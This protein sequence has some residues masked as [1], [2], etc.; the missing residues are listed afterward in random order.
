MPSPLKS[1]L[2]LGIET[3]CD[4]TAAAVLRGPRDVLS[5]IIASQVPIHRR[6]GGVVPE[7]A[8]R[9]HILA[10]DTVVTE[11]L[12]TAGV[13]LPELGG[14]AV[15]FGP[16][17]VGSLL[18][19]VSVAK[20]LAMVHELPLA[21]VNHHEG[22]IQS[23]FIE[24]ADIPLPMIMLMV[25]GGDTSLYLIPEPGA[26][27]P[28]AHTRDDAAGEAYDKVSK[29]LGLGYPGGPIIDR[30]AKL[31]DP[32]AV[33]FTRPR[34]SDGTLDFSFSGMKTAVL[35]YVQANDIRPISSDTNA[36]GHAAASKPRELHGH[37]TTDVFPASN[38]G[39]A[40]SPVRDVRDVQDVPARVLDLLASFQES[41]V[42]YLIDHTVKA[43][44]LHQARSIGLSG[45]VAC[46]SR[47]REAARQTGERLGIP[48]FFP[49]PMLTT[50]NGAMIASAGYHHLIQGR[51]AGY[52][53]NA[54]PGARL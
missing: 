51:R 2:I 33:A 16:G 41:L 18:I 35:R 4:E 17:L 48:V 42:Q 34:M 1:E 28:L 39:G 50:D 36:G 5:N 38:G 40:E 47:L 24:H 46:N 19:G 52:S 53:L 11:A 43:A 9:Q 15:T 14:I 29:L 49:S 31:G 12:C 6:F 21:A 3:S 25:S 13:T 44:R 8:S 37:A 32:K 54:D 20:S 7:L 27:R 10:I 45:G 30:L 23:V 26:Y 22:H